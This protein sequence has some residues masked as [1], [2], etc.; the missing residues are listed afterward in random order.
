VL[1]PSSTT[2]SIA[3]TTSNTHQATIEVDLKRFFE[4][5]FV[6]LILISFVLSV[7]LLSWWFQS[8]LSRADEF[9]KSHAGWTTTAELAILA[10]GLLSCV[11]SLATHYCDEAEPWLA[12]A[13]FLE[14]C[15]I[16]KVLS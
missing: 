3:T 6:L 2:G 16:R 9:I 11:Y 5:Y 1:N 4:G 14:T 7:A 12:A 15:Q 10:I 13:S 8:S